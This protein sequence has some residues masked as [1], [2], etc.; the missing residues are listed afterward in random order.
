MLQTCISCGAVFESEP[1]V[2]GARLDLHGR[3]R[4]LDCLPYRPHH[5][6]AP[7]TPRP[8][9][10]KTCEACGKRFSAK[11]VID[12]KL[13]SLY[14]RRFCLDCSP[15]GSHNTSKTPPGALSPDDLREHRRKRRNAKAYRWQKKHRRELKAAIIELL[16]GK[17]IDCGYQACP[18][19]LD[20]HHVDPS[21]KEFA[22]SSFRGSSTRLR[23]ELTKCV[24]LCANCHRLRHALED[25]NAKGGPVVEFRRRMKAR[26]VSYMGNACAGCGRSGHQ[27]IFDFHHLDPAE[28]KFGITT[29]GIPRPWEK[30]LA[31]LAKCV[32]LCANCHRE[33]HAGVRKLDDLPGLAEDVGRY[34]A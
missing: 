27:A 30:V 33:V 31:E 23:A 14:R 20:P 18:A 16:G 6:T 2:N 15:F 12:G 24:L 22:L 4:C 5:R 32:M 3:K 10:T 28:K 13:R 34:A 9:A 1:V 17:C 8:V 19:A 21:E 7:P 26:A 11:V 25:V 29:D